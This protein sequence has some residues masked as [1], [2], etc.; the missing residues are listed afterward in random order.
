MYWFFMQQ[1]ES[2]P[3]TKVFGTEIMGKKIP[4]ERLLALKKRL[5][6]LPLRNPEL[7]KMIRNLS[8]HEYIENIRELHGAFVYEY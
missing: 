8:D 4:E 6:L 5:D 7:M 3:E 2:V 1:Q